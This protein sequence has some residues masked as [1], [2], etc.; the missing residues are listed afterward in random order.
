MPNKL[1]EYNDWIKENPIEFENQIHKIANNLTKEIK[2]NTKLLSEIYDED[3]YEARIV[4]SEYE[5]TVYLTM[6]DKSTTSGHYTMRP[7][8]YEVV[9]KLCIEW[10]YTKGYL[11]ESGIDRHGKYFFIVKAIPTND[12]QGY[13]FLSGGT[14]NS[15]ED[16][17]IK[18]CQWILENKE[19]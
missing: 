18:G 19:K 2:M 7:N 4:Q 12:S 16:G 15:R 10:S 8:L 13:A 6:H 17:I 14:A 1:K 11:V 9:Y 3:I 5:D